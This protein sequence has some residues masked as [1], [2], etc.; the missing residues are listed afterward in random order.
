MA[1][2]SSEVYLI[3]SLFRERQI[4]RRQ[5]MESTKPQGEWTKGFLKGLEDSEQNLKSII[6]ELEGRK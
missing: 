2:V 5:T 4:R 6:E 3:V 1:K